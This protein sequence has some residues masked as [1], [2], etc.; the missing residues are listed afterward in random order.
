MLSAASRGAGEDRGSPP[1]TGPAQGEGWEDGGGG[2]GWEEGFG[3]A[4]WAEEL[5]FEEAKSQQ[6]GLDPAEFRRSSGGAHG[7]GPG[8][9]AAAGG[10]GAGGSRGGTPRRQVRLL[11]GGVGARWVPCSFSF[12]RSR[13]EGGA[14][15]MCAAVVRWPPV[16]MVLDPFSPLLP[17]PLLP[18][19]AHSIVP[20][21]L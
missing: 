18:P 16:R 4:G 19:Q 3:G 13:W 12:V 7:S 21:P 6:R 15:G 14:P 10:G 20:W 9:P 5:V 2:E 8:S 17:P 11:G 1:A